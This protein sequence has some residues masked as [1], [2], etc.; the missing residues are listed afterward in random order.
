MNLKPMTA[1]QRAAGGG[2]GEYSKA[3][4]R[5]QPSE[6]RDLILRTMRTTDLL[7]KCGA[8]PTYYFRGKESYCD[9]E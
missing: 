7:H 5:S 9:P 6:E 2:A 1:K 8:K 4:E 3:R